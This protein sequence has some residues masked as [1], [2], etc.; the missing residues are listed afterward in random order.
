[1]VQ[2]EK[3]G[4]ADLRNCNRSTLLS[5][6]GFVRRSLDA[7]PDMISELE[8]AELPAQAPAAW[9]R[10][11]MDA[12]VRKHCPSDDADPEARL[13]KVLRWLRARVMLRCFAR[14]L[15]G[16]A[17]LEEVCRC[18]SDLA[19]CAISHGQQLLE[20]LL[21]AQYGEPMSEDGLRPQ[22]L[23]VLG[24]GKLG[25]ME[26]NVSSDIDLIFVYA[27][28]GQLRRSDGSAGSLSN[29]EFFARLGR[30]LIALLDQTTADGRVFRVD[31]RLRPWGDPG[32][33]A[34]SFDALENYLVSQGREWERYAWIKARAITGQASD[35]AALEAITRPFVFRKYLDYGAIAA[36]RE[37]HAQIRAEVARRELAEHVKLG[38]GG[39]REVE[40]IAQAF[41]LIR[42]GRD[43]GLRIR[44]TLQVLTQL[45]QRELLPADSL[46]ELAE[47]YDFLRRV[48]HRLQYA[49][50]AQ[51]HELPQAAAAR[52]LLAASMGFASWKLFMTALNTHRERV[53][54]HFEAVFTTEEKPQHPLVSLWLEPDTEEAARQLQKLGFADA[55]N[56]AATGQNE[57]LARLQAVRRGTRYRELP[58]ASRQR[59]DAL[60]PR[61]LATAATQPVPSQALARLLDLFEAISRRAS[62]L[63]LLDENPQALAEVTHLLAASPWAAEYLIRH[64]ILLDELLDKRALMAA[65]DWSEW[66]D[67]LRQ[68]LQEAGDDLE[69]AFDLSRE[70]HHAQIFRL[71]AQDLAGGLTVE[72]L[73]DLLSDLADAALGVIL[74]RCWTLLQQRAAGGLA[75]PAH[76]TPRFA[77]IA[78]GKLGG[79]ELGYASDL[80]I[81]FLYDDADEAAPEA[82]ARLA[83]R[84]NNWLSSRTQAG[85]L[86][87]TDLRLR[88]DGAAGLMV[89]SMD[90]F[91]RYQRESAWVW[92]HQALTRA[93][94]CA[95]D[96]AI[97]AAFEQE[98]QHILSRPRERSALRAAVLEMR[99]TLLQAHPNPSALFDLKHDRGGMV[100]I[101]FMVQYLVLAESHQHAALLRNAGNIAL[102]GIAG[103]LGLIPATLASQVQQAYRDFRRQQ[104][105]LRLRGERYARIA[106]QQVQSD[107]DATLALWQQLFG[108]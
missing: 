12:F 48:E 60:M 75:M 24:M 43:A 19:D 71:L 4:V 101:E 41:Q 103:D 21:H 92:E 20:R 82:Y 5:H 17:S 9:D 36:M 38:P 32:P 105:Q 29:H 104:H 107:I 79:K 108:S 106:P 69:R 50:D 49:E 61:A 33:L 78:Y 80:D 58:D 44:P 16:Q 37:L 34:M 88:P 84:F 28:D 96:P 95:G 99:Q 2:S 52:K 45:G 72:A 93:R 66:A 59:F 42:G 8:S 7:H 91:R 31:M 68:L 15:R 102:L 65:P 57:T 1:M 39:I 51:T 87:E 3:T 94:F 55:N 77:V 14:D 46:R 98:R 40:F 83:Q 25:G 89:S 62:Y 74:Q 64:P 73:A 18:M 86:F 85:I 76:P 22:R 53:S 47:A 90:A 35:M 70:A 23:I 11:S 56:A 10:S 27:E 30:R 54:R 13:E 81:I 67:K 100:D 26:L 6:S 97:G 63:A